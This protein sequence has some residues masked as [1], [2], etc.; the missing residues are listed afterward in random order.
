MGQFYYSAKAFDILERLDPSPEFWEGKRG[1]CVGVLQMVVAGHEP[2]ESL[3]DVMLILKGSSQPQAELILMA[4]KKW[5][6]EARVT[7]GL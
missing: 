5:T 3:K 7:S 1:A 6:Q 2:K 4:I